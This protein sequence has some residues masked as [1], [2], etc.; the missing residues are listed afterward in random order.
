MPSFSVTQRGGPPPRCRASPAWVLP[1][2]SVASW[3]AVS[4]S[5]AA[6]SVGGGSGPGRATVRVSRRERYE[7]HERRHAGEPG[8]EGTRGRA[9]TRP[10]T[11]RANIGRAASMVRAIVGRRTADRRRKREGVGMLRIPRPSSSSTTR[12]RSRPAAPAR[13]RRLSRRPGTRRRRGAAAVRR[14]AVRPRGARRDAAPGRRA[15]GVCRRLRAESTVPIIMLTARDDELD[16]V[17]GLELG[18]DDYITKPFSIREFRSRVR[19]LLRRA[20]TP[21]FSSRR[22]EAIEQGGV[23]IDPYGAPSRCASGRTAHLRRV[24][25]ACAARIAGPGVVFSRRG[26]WTRLRAAPTTATR[27]RSTSTSATCARRSS[28]AG[29]PELI[30]T[31]RG[32][33]YRFGEA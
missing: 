28:E 11:E 2:S 16:K 22:D 31:V 14:R 21:H 18:A 17:L 19:A 25:A 15:R 27:G 29:S 8:I 4:S 13:A 9:A 23:R 7:D 5:K 3:S 26:C 24:R 10:P 30:L 6:G 12:T 1:A 33:G 20:A 32:V